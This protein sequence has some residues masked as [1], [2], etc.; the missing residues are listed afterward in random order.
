MEF[1]NLG[2]INWF[3]S[4]AIYHALAHLGREALVICTP[5]SPYIC[6]GY[7]QDL[8]SEIDFEA[9]RRKGLPVFRREVGGGLVYLDKHQVFFQ[10]ILNRKNPSVPLNH[11]RFYSKF[12][13]PVLN[14]LKTYGLTA[15]LQPPCDLVIQ[16]KKISGNGA[17]QIGNCYVL[18][19][20]ILLDF[21]YSSM[22]AVIKSPSERFRREYLH[23]M[24]RN[25]TTL[26]AETG[27]SVDTEEVIEL[28]KSHFSKIFH[29]TSTLPDSELE[30]KIKELSPLYKSQKWLEERGHRL[31]YR[32]IKV[33]E[34][35]YIRELHFNCANIN[36]NCLLVISN[37]RIS[38]IELS[39]KDRTLSSP[40]LRQLEN[41]LMGREINFPSVQAA[42]QSIP[43]LNPLEAND[44]AQALIK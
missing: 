20:N 8:L 34:G 25:I 36:L 7:H 12:L 16:T 23:Q 27:S 33:N 39:T 22:A 42:L 41:S 18:V 5:A 1:Y 40:L 38:K 21:D 15:K 31:P 6:A 44:L 43:I 13:E 37:H 30:Q 19:G 26:R 29:L 3:D 24:Q 35:C 28:L 32:N 14:T 9:C 4:Q 2:E 11:D 17:G 10:I